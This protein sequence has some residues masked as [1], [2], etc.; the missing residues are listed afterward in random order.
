M[1]RKRYKELFLVDFSG[2][3]DKKTPADELLISYSNRLREIQNFRVEDGD[4]V[5]RP[6]NS[7]WNADAW[8]ETEYCKGLFRYYYSGNKRFIIA[9]GTDIRVGTP[10]SPNSISAGAGLGLTGLT[11]MT[12]AQYGDKCYIAHDS[13][14]AGAIRYDGTS[15]VKLADEVVSTPSTAPTITP[16]STTIFSMDAITGWTDSSSEVSES[17]ETAEMYEGTGCLKWTT[18]SSPPKNYNL[19]YDYGAGNPQDWSDYKQKTY[20]VKLTNSAGTGGVSGMQIALKWS[21]DG[22][23]WYGQDPVTIVGDMTWQRISFD[24]SGIAEAQRDAIRYVRFYI[25][26]SPSNIIHGYIDYLVAGGTVGIGEER[27]Y[28]Y[29]YYNSTTNKSSLMS[30]FSASIK[31]INDLI[32]NLIAGARSSQ[33]GVNKVRIYRTISGADLTNP[34]VP[35]YLVAEIDNPASGSW[36]YTD[37]FTDSELGDVYNEYNASGVQ[38]PPE[39][40]SIVVLHKDRM[41]WSGCLNNPSTL[42]VSNRNDPETCP[43]VT[44]PTDADVFDDTTG[45]KRDIAKQDG[46]AL[47]CV[48]PFQSSVLLLKEQSFYVWVGDTFNPFGSNIF[49]YDL[50]SAQAGCVG[51]WAADASENEAIWVGRNTVWMWRAGELFDIGW[52]IASIIQSIPSAY[53]KFVDVRYHDRRMH[54]AYTV[55]GGTYNSRKLVYDFRT[56]AWTDETGQNIGVMVVGKNPGDNNELWYGSSN[57]AY[58][59]Q[60]ET[61]TSDTGVAIAGKILTGHLNNGTETLALRYCDIN[62]DGTTSAVNATLGVYRNKNASLG[63]TFDSSSTYALQGSGIIEVEGSLPDSALAKKIQIGLNVSATEAVKIRSICIYKREVR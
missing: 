37:R 2:G 21:E 39:D 49:R 17:L 34:D 32:E 63:D 22:T 11:Q 60:A 4:L 53:Q 38:A 55:S 61:G 3:M 56:G 29:T 18:T 54:I 27:Q 16:Q 51:P 40:A 58:I 1:S 30:P 8:S 26:N 35:F 28:G 10:G 24:I 15:F 48:L 42:Y 46:Q 45:G 31:N 33:S 6:G 52:P 7:K 9:C 36:S 57:T 25:Y 20:W 44:W 41:Y 14:A 50:I 12:A 13:T 62:A 19:R 23:T 47:T 43:T 5:L 59:Y